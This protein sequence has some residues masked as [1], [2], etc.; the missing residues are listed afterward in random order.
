MG[1]GWNV[2]LGAMRRWQGLVAVLAMLCAAPSFA[3]VITY[4]ATQVGGTTWR[5]DYSVDNDSLD[6]PVEEF[7]LFFGLDQYANLSALSAPEGWDGFI[8]QP[9]PLL[10][11]DGFIDVL[12]LNSG[13]LPGQGLSGFSIIF[14]WLL[15]GTPGAQRFDIIEP[16]SFTVIESGFTTLATTASVPEPSS[17]ALFGAALLGFGMFRRRRERLEI[18]VHA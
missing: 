17:L 1:S 7:T 13:V 12:A 5:Y 3:T 4:Q 9:D 14:D 18:G 8:A 6:T 10:P 11:D 2:G 15:E 16:L